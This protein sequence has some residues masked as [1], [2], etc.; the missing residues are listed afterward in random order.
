M[1]LFNGCSLCWGWRQNCFTWSIIY[2]P[3]HPHP[4]VLLPTQLLQ[5]HLIPPV[6]HFFYSNDGSIFQPLELFVLLPTTVPL[7]R[8]F[9]QPECSRH[10][11][12]YLPVLGWVFPDTHFDT[13]TWVCVICWK[14]DPESTAKGV[15]TVSQE[16]GEASTGAVMRR[17]L[18]KAVDAETH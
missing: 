15:G 6:P 10:P 8:P 13:G 7:C 17:L 2:L 1:K 9:L 12:S 3:P 18:E 4:P 11:Y 5:I 14:G 16:K